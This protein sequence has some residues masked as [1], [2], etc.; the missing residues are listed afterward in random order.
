MPRARPLDEGDGGSAVVEYVLVSVLLVI[1][2][3]AIAQLALVIHA[4]DVLV[5]DAAEGARVAAL[6][7]SSMASGEQDCA[8][9]VRQTLSHLV[10]DGSGPCAAS[11]LGGDPA[12]VAMR[13]QVT[14]PLTL[15]PFGRVHLDVQARAIQEPLS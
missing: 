8:S 7:D 9:L 5:A 15:V 13:V 12:L 1:V 3:L 11:V 4:R 10:T 14:V 6:R 2:F